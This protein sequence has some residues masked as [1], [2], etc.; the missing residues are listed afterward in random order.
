VPIAAQ[1]H[2]LVNHLL[3]SGIGWGEIYEE[4]MRKAFL[5]DY[6]SLS[7]R[8]YEAI[9]SELIWR[10]KP[11]PFTLCSNP[12]L[13]YCMQSYLLSCAPARPKSRRLTNFTQLSVLPLRVSK[14]AADAAPNKTCYDFLQGFLLR[15]CFSCFQRPLSLL[16]PTC[17]PRAFDG[18]VETQNLIRLSLQSVV[19]WAQISRGHNETVVRRAQQP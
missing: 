1:A 10:G 14:E 5:A 12:F 8:W 3:A 16:H 19:R 7:E 13:L 18:E 6:G 2:H 9:V 15:V 11:M 17:L 4:A